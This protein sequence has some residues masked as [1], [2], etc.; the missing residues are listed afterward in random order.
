MTP[1]P[2]TSLTPGTYDRDALVAGTCIANFASAWEL[3]YDVVPCS[4]AHQA[5]VTRVGQVPGFAAGAFPDEAIVA[6]TVLPLCTEIGLVDAAT[7]QAN[8]ALEYTFAYP[9]T[10]S[11]WR[12]T[13]GEF[14]CFVSG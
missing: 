2:V 3:T 9:V 4:L 12:E 6:E 13:R 5:K 7:A 1:S 11:Q 14:V 10:A 8:P